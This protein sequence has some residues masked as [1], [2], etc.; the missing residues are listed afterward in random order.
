MSVR[1]KIFTNYSLLFANFQM[2]FLPLAG[3]GCA[4]LAHPFP[5]AAGALAGITALRWSF[6]CDPLP[7]GGV[8]AR[9]QKPTSFSERRHFFAQQGGF[10][11]KLTAP[12]LYKKTSA[13]QQ[14]FRLLPFCGETG[15]R[16]LDTRRYNGF[17]D[18]P[19]RPLRHLSN[20]VAKRVISLSACKCTN[21]F[22][23]PKFKAQKID[24]STPF[25]YLYTNY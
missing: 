9:W 22:Q 6:V 13:F 23:F 12:L 2:P 17:R 3:I 5:L 15:I 11:S 25:C 4:A 8:L 20:R 19:D 7:A 21:K 24:F 10:V 18:R 16:T 14:R 1:K